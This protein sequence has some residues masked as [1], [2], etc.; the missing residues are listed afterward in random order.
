MPWWTSNLVAGPRSSW[1]R[2][3]CKQNENKTVELVHLCY[4]ISLIASHPGLAA[5]SNRPHTI[6]LTLV[7][8]LCGVSNGLLLLSVPLTTTTTT[9]T[10][11]V[12]HELGWPCAAHVWACLPGLLHEMGRSPNRIDRAPTLSTFH[13]DKLI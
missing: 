11:T 5:P 9:T 3:V 8:T 13:F 6:I 7:A 12:W 1:H 4:R 10:T 2:S